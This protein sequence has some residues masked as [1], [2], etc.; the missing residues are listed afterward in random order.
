MSAYAVVVTSPATCTWPVMISVSTATRLFGSSANSASRIESLI[1]SA[2]LSGCPSV[3]DSDVKRRRLTKRSDGGFSKK[4]SGTVYPAFPMDSAQPG[5][6]SV[7]Q[8]GGEDRLR[9]VVDDR[10]AAVGGEDHTGVVGLP[11]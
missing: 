3:T 11:E 8:R 6:Y 10:L 1:W 2:I 5:R 4:R 7:P 9:P